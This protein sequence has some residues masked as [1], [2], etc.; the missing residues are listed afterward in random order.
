MLMLKNNISDT[1]DI[2][3]SWNELLSNKSYPEHYRVQQLALG[4]LGFIP[5]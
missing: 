1:N 5:Q 3:D 2:P 4:E